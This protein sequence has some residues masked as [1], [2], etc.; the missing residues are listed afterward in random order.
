MR[1]AAESAVRQTEARYHPMILPP[2]GF[3]GWG[4]G[5]LEYRGF[6]IGRDGHVR[7][8]EPIVC[9][10]DEAAIAAAKRLVDRYDVELWQADRKVILLSIG[11]TTGI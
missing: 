9:P 5:M 11:P 6:F 1:D 4:T 10:N 8:F 2:L 7:G 3:W